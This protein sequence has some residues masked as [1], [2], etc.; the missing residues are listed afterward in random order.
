[1]DN[2]TKIF[3]AITAGAVAGL[4]LGLLLAPE[5]GSDTQ[6]IVTDKAKGFLDELLDKVEDFLTDKDQEENEKSQSS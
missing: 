5:K 3:V 4:A 2:K 6:K 1:M